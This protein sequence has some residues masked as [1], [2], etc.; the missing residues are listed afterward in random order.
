M[1][2]MVRFTPNDIPINKKKRK[3]E[4]KKKTQNL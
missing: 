3:E 4:G 2:T 1:F